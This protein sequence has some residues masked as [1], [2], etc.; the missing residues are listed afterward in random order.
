M[1]ILAGLIQYDRKVTLQLEILNAE[2]INLISSANSTF[3]RELGDIRNTA[4]LL[5]I[6]LQDLLES[7]NESTVNSFSRVGASLPNVSQLRW[8][9][10]EGQ[11]VYRVNFAGMGSEAVSAQNL[12]N[13]AH[14]SYF[15][16]ILNTLPGELILSDIDLN[17]ENGKVVT[18][19]EPTIRALLHS[20][21]NHPLGEGFLIVNFRLT[22]LFDFLS[23]LS[24]TKTQLLVAE[25]N[26]QWLIHPDQTKQWA[27]VL[28]TGQ[29]SLPDDIP[30]LWQHLNTTPAGSLIEG[31][32]DD[33]YSV[34]KSYLQLSE[35]A[36]KRTT[37]YFIA[38]TPRT[39]YRSIQQQ[40]LTP[41]VVIA[42]VVF[43][44]GLLL[45][46]REAVL[47][48]RVKRLT[49]LL[50]TEKADLADALQHQQVLQDELVEVEKMASLGMLV[51]GVS[52]ELNTPIGAAVMTVS[53]LQRKVN[54]LNKCI[55]EGLTRSALDEHVQ[56]SREATELALTN[57][58]RASSLIQRFKRLAVDRSEEIQMDF[59]LAQAVYD[60]LDAMKPQLKGSRLQIEVDVPA[61][62]FMKSYPGT[63]SQVLQNLINNAMNHAFENNNGTIAIKAERMQD[64]VFV[65][66]TDNGLGIA[67]DVADS[68]FDPFV[69]TNRG[70]GNSGLG[71]H[72]VHRWVTHVMQGHIQVNSTPGQGTCFILELPVSP[73]SADS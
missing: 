22:S 55:A 11:E 66:V 32:Q 51:A 38:R 17:I 13:K 73:A 15:K 63:L 64:L 30:R 61:S 60:L 1:A 58:Q 33:I 50:K 48:L 3:N 19:L 36:D 9:N 34:V 59:N 57:L 2:H 71:L 45:I 41:A 28:Q 40:A 43:C 16:T 27:S 53:G 5:S 42:L 8:L 62:I 25:N 26:D 10:M 49:Q 23:G 39:L 20:T 67:Q 65:T 6:H 68:L 47:G 35:P 4:R 21:P 72:L 29:H 18:P 14:R 7:Q 52:H 31:E 70:Q 37:L 56:Q 69:T 12:Q 46:Y 44:I 54:E 24:D